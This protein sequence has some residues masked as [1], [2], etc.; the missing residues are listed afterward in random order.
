MALLVERLK[1]KI[2]S[3]YVSCPRKAGEG[4]FTRMFTCGASLRVA[5]DAVK[6]IRILTCVRE[7]LLAK[8]MNMFLKK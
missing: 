6:C 1:N 4:V 5:N 8:I 2:C 7:N 3:G